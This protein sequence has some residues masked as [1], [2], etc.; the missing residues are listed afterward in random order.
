MLTATAAIAMSTT[1]WPMLDT[2]NTPFRLDTAGVHLGQ[3]RLA[4]V[5]VD[6]RAIRQDFDTLAESERFVREHS[7]LRRG[8][9]VRCEPQFQYLFRGV[10]LDQRPR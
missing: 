10:L 4:V 1:T 6:E 5:G 3:R 9:A 8:V 2:V 7:V